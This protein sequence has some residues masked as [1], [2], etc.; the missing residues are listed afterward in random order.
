[1][2]VVVGHLAVDKCEAFAGRVVDS[3]MAGRKKAS[4]ELA[5][6]GKPRI[7]NDAQ[8]Q[9]VGR[10]AEYAMCLA[11]GIDPDKG[12]NWTS[13]CDSGFDLQ[14][15]DR[16]T[17]DVKASSHPAARKLIWPVSKKYFLTKAADVLVLA[18]VLKSRKEPL[19]QVVE[20]V[21]WVSRKEFIGKHRLA[22]SEPGMVD[23]TLYMLDTDLHPMEALLQTK[24]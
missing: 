12:L 13:R 3:Y 24:S 9:A 15:A 6:Q 1:M 2:D 4:Q 21:G 11:A 20:L 22:R 16:R 17:V 19:G 14:L 8:V 10:I 18:R 23:G 5:V 7:D